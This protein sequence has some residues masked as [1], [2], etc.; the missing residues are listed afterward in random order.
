M[1]TLCTYG[2]GRCT[3]A[4]DFGVVPSTALLLEKEQ[5]GAS[6]I[7]NRMNHQIVGIQR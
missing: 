5:E 3:L 1:F 6:D 2:E 4:V 7:R